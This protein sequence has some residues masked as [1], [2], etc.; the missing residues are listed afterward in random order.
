[1]A[2]TYTAKA[3]FKAMDKMSRPFKQMTKA[4]LNFAQKT[5]VAFA[6]VERRTRRL[7][8]SISGLLGKVG[9]L[10]LGFGALMI[11][12]QIATANIELD[13]SLQSLQA[14]TGVT[15]DAFKSFAKEID[16]VSKRQ[17]IFAGET[18]KA[19]ELV[20]SA[21]PELLANAEAL[22]AVTEQALI[23]SKA[24][25][26]DVVDA[27][28]SLTVSMNQFGVG[29]DK[30]AEFVDILATA[31]QKGSGTIKFLSEAM[32][33]A[34]GTSKAFG[35]SFADTVAVLEG[36]AKA[37][38]PASEAGTQLAGILSKLSKAQ[39]K[40]F[41]P[42]F[43]KTTDIINNLA[44][45]NLSYTDLL[46][47]T[48]V[49][50]AKWLTTI[51]NQNEIVQQLT[52]NLNDTGNAQKQANIQMMSLGNILKQIQAA[53]KNVI[54]S[55]NSESKS[56]IKLK[57]SLFFVAENM[58]KIIKTIGALIIAFASFTAIM[59]A[60]KI[61]IVG[62]SIA[63]GVMTALSTKSIFA[64]RGNKIAMAAYKTVTII[65][66]A[67]QW[68]FAAAVNAGL[69]PILAVIAVIGILISIIR[70]LIKNWKLVKAAF[71]E[72][73][74][75]KGL[76]AIGKVILDAILMPVQKLL[77]LL[78]K[79]PG[80]KIAAKGAEGIEGFR[81]R[82]FESERQLLP[83]EELTT[84]K[85][86]AEQESVKREERISKQQATLNINNNTGF[87]TSVEAPDSFPIALSP[88]N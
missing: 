72:G 3:E 32:V 88:T 87:E 29:A 13:D 25:K 73:G 85:T 24:G 64:L 10:G 43:T 59:T 34:G 42:Q 69:W 8:K 5:E 49:R 52:G 21:K 22:S 57:E 37:G 17:L 20:G 6:R 39:N 2:A 7:Q 26:L 74:I 54:S 76:L 84:T 77:E 61:S 75:L 82:L 68:L 9:K 80:L 81:N 18:A 63:L 16:N 86:A 56:M 28:N 15:G 50:G 67:A 31:Q 55:T 40:N 70:S 66:T 78:G 45:A 1:M 62:Y 79:I 19:F 47:L 35:N 60:V 44:K 30:A 83:K 27:V 4:G 38:V 14:I 36:F 11:A 23:L 12:G 71:S 65:A 48:D 53:F 33:N 51:I 41:N 46:K 58:G